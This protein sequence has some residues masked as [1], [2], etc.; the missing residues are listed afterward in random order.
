MNGGETIAYRCA[1]KKHRLILLVAK[2]A[3]CMI[4][5]KKFSIAFFNFLFPV[6]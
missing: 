1:V 4:S 3:N 2:V 5:S 6:K